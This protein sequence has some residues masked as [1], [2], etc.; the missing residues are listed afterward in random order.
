MRVCEQLP[1]LARQAGKL[2]IART[3][4][5]ADNDHASAA[6]Q[7]TTGNAYPRP[8]NLSGKSTRE[9]HPH[10]GSAVAAIEAEHCPVPPFAMVPQYLVVNGEFRSGQNAGFLGSRFDPL[11]PGGIPTIRT[12][13][14]SI[15][16]WE[17]RSGQST[18]GIDISC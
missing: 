10:I 6:Y 11:V 16:A 7:M 3:V 15:S 17:P 4:C 12:S 1:L 18:C 13:N 5:H 2:T 14:P 9:D 8:T